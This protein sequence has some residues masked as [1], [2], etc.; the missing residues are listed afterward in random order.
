MEIVL[1]QVHPPSETFH[2]GAVLGA[3]GVE[4]GGGHV[5]EQVRAPHELRR[6]EAHAS[7]YCR[8]QRLCGGAFSVLGKGDEALNVR[9][10]DV[11]V[12]LVC[13]SITGPPALV[14]APTLLATAGA[15]GVSSRG[16][17]DDWD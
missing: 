14:D 17:D 4:V 16:V 8:A 3:R 6:P 10:R 15:A 9:G 7:R 2:V 12:V 11:V 13:D 5:I 1:P